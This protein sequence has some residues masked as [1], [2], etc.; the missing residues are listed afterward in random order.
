MRPKWNIERLNDRGILRITLEIRL[1]QVPEYIVNEF[2]KNIQR[3]H[4]K[5]ELRQQFDAL[6]NRE[7]KVLLQ[8]INGQTSKQISARLNIT[9]N[10]VKTHRKN[11][12]RKLNCKSVQ[13][14]KRYEV[15]FNQ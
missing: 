3:N 1:D 5:T 11:I 8:V 6:S 7:R 4:V 14:L 2:N 15:L 13:E 12:S 9:E 10:T